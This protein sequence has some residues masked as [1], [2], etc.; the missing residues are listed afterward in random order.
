MKITSKCVTMLHQAFLTN[1]VTVPVNPCCP[2]TH[3][4]VLPPLTTYANIGVHSSLHAL[5][6]G[7][8]A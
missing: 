5:T 6:C 4:A 2:L 3:R 1:V 8:G 7:F